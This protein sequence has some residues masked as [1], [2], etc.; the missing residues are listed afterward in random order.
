MAVKKN[1]SCKL[2]VNVS[3]RKKEFHHSHVSYCTRES[4]S[5]HRWVQATEPGAF[6]VS[7]AGS[8]I[9]TG[10]IVVTMNNW[11]FF[12]V[13]DMVVVELLKGR[14]RYNRRARSLC[15][16]LLH[17]GYVHPRLVFFLTHLGDQVATKPWWAAV[18]QVRATHSLKTHEYTHTHT[19]IKEEIFAPVFQ[20]KMSVLVTIG[21]VILCVHARN[22]LLDMDSSYTH[23][24]SYSRWRNQSRHSRQDMWWSRKQTPTQ[25]L[26]LTTAE[27]SSTSAEESI[28]MKFI[29]IS[30]MWYTVCCCRTEN[31]K[32]QIL[33]SW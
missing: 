9:W 8:A 22:S 30:W 28:H 14:Q 27:L 24:G 17:H 5:A 10:V 26:P 13:W 31:R 21:Q 11:S 12:L 20:S 2:R 7:A 4:R 16:L 6:W 32:L 18:G 15:S 3:S 25:T 1:L 23:A 33:F 19:H 29:W